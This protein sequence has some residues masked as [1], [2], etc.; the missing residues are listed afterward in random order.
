MMLSAEHRIDDRIAAQLREEFLAEAQEHIYLLQDCLWEESAPGDNV[1]LTIR[2]E[3]H[4]LKEIGASFGFPAVTLIAHRLEDYIAGLPVFA[5]HH[6]RDVGKFVDCLSDIVGLGKNPG[7]AETAALLRG[8]PSH[9]SLE[10]T[11]VKPRNVE[12][13]LV[14]PSRA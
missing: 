5:P 12:V 14:I 3:V 1:L 7:G 8:L 13:L 4:S 2:R 6:R 10:P 9:P 11:T